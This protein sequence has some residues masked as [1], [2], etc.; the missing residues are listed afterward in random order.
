VK[1]VGKI[2]SQRQEQADDGKNVHG[3][4]VTYFYEEFNSSPF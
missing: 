3:I 2:K 4:H 1:A